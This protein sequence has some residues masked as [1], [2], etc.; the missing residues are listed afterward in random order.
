[1]ATGAAIDGLDSTKPRLIVIAVAATTPPA[2]TANAAPR[3]MA[4]SRGDRAG[5]VALSRNVRRCALSNQ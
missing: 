1:M 2:A 3:R 4:F 5:T